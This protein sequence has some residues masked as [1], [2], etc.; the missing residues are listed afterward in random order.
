MLGGRMISSKL[1]AILAVLLL[2]L[3]CISIDSTKLNDSGLA[4]YNKGDYAGALADYN[5][6]IALIQKGDLAKNI[7]VIY[8]NRGDARTALGDYSGAVSDYTKAIELNPTYAL[9]YNNMGAIKSRYLKDQQSAIIDLSKAIELKPSYAEAYSNRGAAEYRSGDVGSAKRDI[10]DA[11]RL[12]SSLP[13]FD[14][15]KQIL[16]SE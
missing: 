13:D 5:Q 7:E 9:A 2:L 3:G 6:A 16:D 10:D 4:K 14:T 11:Y 1:M 12:D 15:L 8:T